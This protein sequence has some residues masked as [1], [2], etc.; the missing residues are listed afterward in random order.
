VSH[1]TCFIACA[2]TEVQGWAEGPAEGGGMAPG[3]ARGDGGSRV[4]LPPQSPIFGS[5]V[6]F[7]LLKPRLFPHQWLG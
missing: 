4:G 3:A 6:Q 5:F 2:F 7:E 1:P